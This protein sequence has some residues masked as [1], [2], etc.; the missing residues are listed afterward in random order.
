MIHAGSET[1]GVPNALL[2]LKSGQRSGD[3]HEK[4][5]ADNFETKLKMKLIPH[6]PPQ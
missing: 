5:N 3:Y 4:I 1:G 6:L 2:D